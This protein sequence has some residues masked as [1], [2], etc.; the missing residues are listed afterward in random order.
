ML[1]I[2]LFLSFGKVKGSCFGVS[3]STNSTIFLQVENDPVLGCAGLSIILILMAFPF[4]TDFRM[5]S[6]GRVVSLIL[7][8]F[9]C[10]LKLEPQ[11]SKLFLGKR[12]LWTVGSFL[13]S[14]PS[15]ETIRV[16]SSGLL[17]CR[18]W[19][20]SRCVFLWA[21]GYKGKPNKASYR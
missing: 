3:S 7:K 9:F 13:R 15:A 6:S 2:L 20:V 4:P 10:A 12:T 21:W 1:S 8:N 18:C 19:I 14:S 17:T 11:I 16:L 5:N